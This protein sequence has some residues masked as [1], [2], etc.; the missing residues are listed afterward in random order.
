LDNTLADY[1]VADRRPWFAD[2]KKCGGIPR[3]H[4]IAIGVI[5]AIMNDR[6]RTSDE[7]VSE[8]LGTLSN[9]NET[10]NDK[11]IPDGS[12]DAKKAPALTEARKENTH[13][14]CTIDL[15]KVESLIEPRMQEEIMRNEANV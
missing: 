11:S 3:M 12:L 10:F 13:L 14:D 2:A 6:C 5:S 1:Q 9:M 7:K 8:T 15:S 4:S